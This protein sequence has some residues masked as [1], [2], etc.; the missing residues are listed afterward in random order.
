MRVASMMFPGIGQLKGGD[1]A[2]GV[3]FLAGD[4]L[5][6]AATLVGVYFLLPSELRFGQLNYLTTPVVD[7]EAAWK[8][9]GES[10]S[11]LDSLPIMGVVCG[12]MLL[13]HVL[14]II[15]GNQAAKLARENI[16][17]GKVTFEPKASFLTKGGAHWGIGMGFSS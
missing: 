17:S 2:S 13:H 16:E 11:L 14:G 3:L 6:A 10:A 12:G 5:V 9:A 7:I 4:T 1:T 8:S 15:S